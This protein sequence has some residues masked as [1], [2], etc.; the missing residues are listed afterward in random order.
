[1]W[2]PIWTAVI[3]AGGLFLGMLA[4][5][6]AGRAVG[7]RR[8]RTDRQGARAGITEVE[9]AV[10]ALLGLLIAFTFSGAASRFDD[11]RR[12]V[13]QEVN[14]IGT[15][16]LRLDLLPADHR[17]EMR[18]LFRR[19]LDSRI[20]SY[21]R[22]P[23]VDAAKAEFA[24]SIRLQ[25]EIWNRAI[26]AVNAHS[27]RESD[28]RLILPALN[29]MF[30]IVTTRTN[31]MRIHPPVIIFAMLGLLSLVGALLAGYAMAE[32][33]GRSTTHIVSFALVLALTVYVILDIE[34]PRLGLIRMTDT[35]ELMVTLR[36]SMGQ[37][38]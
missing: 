7:R 1:M 15:A 32:A 10:Y 16:W 29:D 35:D 27:A 3:F 30:D 33:K 11:R 28:E 9:S 25:G 5:L 37:G 12:L 38:R 17:D 13:A 26:A 4:M 22:L 19:Y 2:S 8:L 6:E 21:R 34:Y 14:A 36:A 24:R 20:E 23:D 31:A 18:D